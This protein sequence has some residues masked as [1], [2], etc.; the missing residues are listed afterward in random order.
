MPLKSTIA[1]GPEK[2]RNVYP[3]LGINNTK[4]FVVLFTSVNYGVVVWS[5]GP[6]GRQIGLNEGWAETNFTPFNGTIT[7]GEIT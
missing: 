3:Y 6:H 2:P 4:T 7:L 1:F 5:D